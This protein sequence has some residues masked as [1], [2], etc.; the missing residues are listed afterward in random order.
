MKDNAKKTSGERVRFPLVMKFWLLLIVVAV[1][2]LGLIYLFTVLFLENSYVSQKKETVRS[3]SR[4][5]TELVLDAETFYSADGL[6]NAALSEL[7]YENKVCVL[8]MNTSGDVLA[9]YEGIGDVCYVHS[10]PRN[11]IRV[12]EEV[13]TRPQQIVTCDIRSPQSAPQYYICGSRVSKETKLYSVPYDMRVEYVVIVTA[14]FANVTEAAAA[15]RSQ[16][17]AVSLLLL[18]AVTVLALAA[19]LLITR[20]I[21]KLS[22]ASRAVAGGNLEVQADIR[23][24]DEL[25]HLCGDFNEMVGKLKASEQMQREMIAN[26]SHDLRTPLTMIRGYA[27]SIQDVVGE[28]KEERNRQLSVIIEET[29]RL[30][31]LVTDMMDL[32][33]LQTGRR[34][35]NVTEFSVVGLL[36]ETLSR[37]AFLQD[38][39][40]ALRLNS[41]LPEGDALVIGD[42]RR[43]GQV[44]YNFI[45]NAAAH[46]RCNRPDGTPYARDITLTV[47]A[48]PEF[49]TV[50]IAVRDRGEGIPSE[51]LPLIWERYYKASRAAGTTFAG[52]GL[53]LSIVKAI[54][55]AHRAPYG[56]ISAPD[57]GSEFWFSLPVKRN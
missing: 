4:Q 34:K 43:V 42:E 45:G 36:N 40:F 57:E 14:P 17:S 52:T 55:S 54:L 16:L 33:L 38:D 7:A 29:D 48:E 19:A 2:S 50:R 22:E 21:K 20:P 47:S 53:G 13:M 46:S 10:N 18:V 26:V 28:D 49:G 11:L 30:S 25:G 39:G 15:I 56:V 24:R 12:Y 9:S 5:A 3:I 35:L 1:V 6:D 23:T 8:V 27:E 32:S 31:T 41:E 51:E 44:L 37:F